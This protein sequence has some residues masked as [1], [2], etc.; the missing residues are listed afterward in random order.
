MKNNGTQEE[1]YQEMET[2]EMR[3][4]YFDRQIL[5]N[6]F[7]K[8]FERLNFIKK[9]KLNPNKIKHFLHLVSLN[10]N[11]APFHNM[12]HAFNVTQVM[13]WVIR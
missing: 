1:A 12:T 13:Y 4:L 9:F 7:F 10:Y 6:C 11:F 3:Y 5:L 2:M 8:M